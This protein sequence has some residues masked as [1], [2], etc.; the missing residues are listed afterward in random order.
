MSAAHATS[1]QRPPTNPQ[2]ASRPSGPET[3]LLAAACA[4][5]GLRPDGAEILCRRRNLVARLPA[6][7]LPGP[8]VVKIHDLGTARA[9][10]ARQADL[11]R[12]LTDRGFP[13]AAPAGR[14]LV[15]AAGDRWASAV[16]DLGPGEP[17][18]H[19]QLG[20]LIRKLHALPAPTHLGLPLSDPAASLLSR[21][22]RLPDAV[23]PPDERAWLREQI[24]A[25]GT[26]FDAVGWR[27][28]PGLVHG[29]VHLPNTIVARDGS[30]YLLDW[31]TAALGPAAADLVFPAWPVDAFGYNSSSYRDFCEA[32]GAD[33]TTT[34]GGHLYRVLTR[35]TAAV[36]VVIALEE[37]TRDPAWRIEATYRLSCFRHQGGDDP[38]F[39][40]PWRWSISPTTAST[41]VGAATS[42]RR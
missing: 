35:M 32:Y 40:Y 23:L 39:A 38:A 20:M 18:T 26:Q 27:G 15:V 37:T 10:V 13:T 2:P 41:P 16:R 24:A 30:P 28:R 6:T 42:G 33:V 34:D 17:A 21:V 3:V 31:E 8:A 14:H 19:T 4:G 12:W 5:L 1:D 11:A 29:D 7:G 36:G 25:A 9:D 22:T